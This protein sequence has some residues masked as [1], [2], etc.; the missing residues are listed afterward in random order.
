MPSAP[1]PDRFLS[2]SVLCRG[3][4]RP[5][6]LVVVALLLSVTTTSSL[7]GEEPAKLFLQQLRG[8]GY[9]D[10]ALDYLD[11]LD[12]YPGVSAELRDAIQLEKSQIY[13][14]AAGATRNRREQEAFFERGEQALRSFID[15]N[16]SH[17]RVSEARITLGTRQLVHALVLMQTPKLDAETRQRARE[18]YLAASKTFDESIAPLKEQLKALIGDRDAEGGREQTQLLQSQYMTAQLQAA[19]TRRLAAETYPDPVAEGKELLGESLERFT[20][21]SDKYS[22]YLPGAK[23]MLYRG[24][25]QQLLGES[26]AA[27][28]SY[29]RVQ[30]MNDDDVLRPLKFQAAT[31][32]IQLRLAE[33]PPQIDPAINRGQPWIDALRPNERRLREVQEL[34]MALAEAYLA[35]AAAAE[36]PKDKKTAQTEAR[37][38]LNDSKSVPGPHTDKAKELL[39]DLGV[40]SEAASTPEVEQPKSV[41]EALAAA[42]TLI[43]TGDQLALTETVLSDKL[44]EPGGD[45][46]EIREQL[47]AVRSDVQRQRQMAAELLRQG[48]QLVRPGDEL[49]AIT[50]ARNFLAYVLYRLEQYREAAAVGQFLAAT[51]P[52][53]ALGLSGGIYA[54]NA[55]Q[56]LAKSCPDPQRPAV[57]ERLSEVAGLLVQ[58]WPEDPS[59]ASARGTLIMVAINNEQWDDA[60]KFIEATPDDAPNKAYFQ[61]IMGSLVWNRYLVRLQENPDDAGAA[62]LLPQAE[63]DLRAGLQGV[64]PDNLKQP[65]L[66]A[67]LILAKILLRRDQQDAALEVL[68]DANFGPLKYADKGDADFQF[69]T[70]TTALQVIISQM[71][72]LDA[73]TATLTEQ[74]ND[75]VDRM[76]QVAGQ[77]AAAR[78]K[79]AVSFRIL[80]RDIRAQMEAAPPAKQQTLMTAFQTL[81][82]GLANADPSPTTQRMVGQSFADIGESAMANPDR[83]ATGKAAELL[84]AA[85]EMLRQALDGIDDADTKVTLRYLLGRIERQRGNYSKALGELT[86]VVK[87]KPSMLTAQEEAALAYEQWGYAS[88]ETPRRAARAHELAVVGSRPDAKGKNQIWGW[89]GIGRRTG[90]N[91]KFRDAFFKA[92]YHLSLNRFHQGKLENDQRVLQSALAS[93]QKLQVFYPDFGGPEWRPQFDRLAQDIQAQLGKPT[94]GLAAFETPAAG[95]S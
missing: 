35:K 9:Y 69:K 16:P 70:Y 47:D 37:R 28:D 51:R 22:E 59:V 10:V 52:G 39:A 4:V 72:E 24:Q 78:E 81:M 13:L 17:P 67:S 82:S 89:G 91:T 55:L 88:A 63:Q 21:I 79:M 95:G 44:K 93:I 30:E 87:A 8:A 71:T 3:L 26:K 66:D 27:L 60:R 54:L 86:E 25:V 7:R 32:T 62:E 43:E 33:Q 84:S 53:D 18:E 61:R 75:L 64:Q 73:D 90:N 38:L 41:E 80:A 49:E 31:G 12:Q 36:S 45:K 34:R 57:L 76:Q 14:E 50:Q 2:I 48:L 92:R 85:A 74:A 5:G 58:H 1:F 15:N 83:P 11:N 40:A 65:E 56:S 23:A 29:Q 42:R 68:E 77:N 94:A 6:L 46:T 20:T 19:Q